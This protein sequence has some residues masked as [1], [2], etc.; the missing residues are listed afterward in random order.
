LALPQKRKK[1]ET[2]KVIKLFS[3]VREIIYIIYIRYDGA[4]QEEKE[5]KYIGE[6]GRKDD[7]DLFL[8]YTRQKR[9]TIWA[10]K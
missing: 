2:R 9:I 6:V 5:N 10:V 3:K 7:P 4:R 1:K 8:N